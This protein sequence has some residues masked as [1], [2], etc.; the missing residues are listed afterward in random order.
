M[1]D[2]GALRALLNLALPV[3]QV[4]AALSMLFLPFLSRVRS[5]KGS[6]TM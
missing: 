5:E 3:A 6:S 2:V 1:A 4:Y